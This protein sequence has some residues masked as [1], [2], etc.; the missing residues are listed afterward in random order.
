MSMKL[1]MASEASTD[2][3]PTADDPG[4]GDRGCRP[5]EKGERGRLRARS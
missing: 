4:S 2:F 1:R 5:S 3:L